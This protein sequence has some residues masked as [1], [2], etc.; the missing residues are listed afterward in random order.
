MKLI[1]TA[2]KCLMLLGMVI[3][4]ITIKTITLL[5]VLGGREGSYVAQIGI[6][7]N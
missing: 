4:D 2:T 3:T 7:S 1:C 6:L 5:I